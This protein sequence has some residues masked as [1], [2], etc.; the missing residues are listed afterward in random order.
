MWLL[1][2]QSYAADPPSKDQPPLVPCLAMAADNTPVWPS[3]SLP[4]SK[5]VTVVFRIPKDRDAKVL[6]SRWFTT[7]GTEGLV[8]E[9]TLDLKGM[10]TGWLRLE[11]NQPAPSGKYRLDTTLDGKPWESVEFQVTPPPQQSQPATPA[12]LIPL[13]EGTSMTYDMVIRSYGSTRIEVPGVQPDADG[14]YRAAL[15]MSV[16]KVD[17]NGAH[18]T[19]SINGNPSGEMWVKVDEKGLQAVKRK[20]G[21]EIKMLQP[22]QMIQPLPAVLD[23]GTRWTCTTKDKGKQEL[24]LIG[25]IPLEGPDGTAAGYLIFSREEFSTGKPGESASQGKETIERYYIPKVGLIR[26]VHVNVLD[27]NLT[28]REE[29]TLSMGKPFKLVANPKMKGRLGRIEFSYPSETKISE[30][31]VAVFKSGA[32][33]G[34]KALSNG[35]GAAGFDIMPGKYEVAIN[36]KRVPVEVKSGHNTI[37]LCGVLRVHAGSETRFRVLDSDKKTELH[38]AYGEQ[39]V[40]LPPGTYF[41]EIGGASEA[42]KILDGQVTEF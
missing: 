9:S 16:G 38:D 41:L 13:T 2:T 19:G 7:E 10:K 21:D 22:P 1:P 30:A 33:K 15:V 26:E 39:D 28:S 20:T 32:K 5:R 12:D 25:P 23:D 40:A 35:Y 3:N 42:V 27:G 24:E 8:A 14:A 17:E 4:S 6:G 18:Y 36:N 29:I 37:P 34:D 31:R 11:L